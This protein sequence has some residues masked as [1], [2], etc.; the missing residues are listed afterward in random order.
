MCL[1]ETL[2]EAKGRGGRETE[3]RGRGKEGREKRKGQSTPGWHCTEGKISMDAGAP[4][5]RSGLERLGIAD[6]SAMDSNSSLQNL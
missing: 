6:L 5:W 4:G 2:R 1:P 3:W